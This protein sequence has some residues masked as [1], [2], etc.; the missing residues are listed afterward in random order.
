MTDLK[1]QLAE[2]PLIF[3][4]KAIEELMPGIISS[5]TLSNLHSLGRGPQF[6]KIG[7][8]VFYERESFIE[9]FL[10]SSRLIGIEN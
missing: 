1:K 5:K 7:R 4:R 10:R 3:G 9:W 8:R 2:L 6:F